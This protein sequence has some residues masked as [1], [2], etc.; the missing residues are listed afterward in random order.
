M[1]PFQLMHR[2]T[3]RRIFFTMRYVVALKKEKR[4]KKK[5]RI[6]LVL[7][8]ISVLGSSLLYSLDILFINEIFSYLRKRKKQEKKKKLLEYQYFSCVQCSTLILTY[9]WF[10]NWKSLFRHFPCLFVF[11]MENSCDLLVD[12]SALLFKLLCL[13]TILGHLRTG[14]HPNG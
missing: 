5:N 2:S 14:Y 4:K 10:L 7:G 13:L 12:L 1:N 11:Y 9:G 3:L 6:L 8:F